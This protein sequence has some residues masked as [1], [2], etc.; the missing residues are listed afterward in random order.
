[1]GKDS[2]ENKEVERNVPQLTKLSRGKEKKDWEMDEG[3]A[4]CNININNSKINKKATK[5]KRVKVNQEEADPSFRT[6]RD[7]VDY[8]EENNEKN[9][10]ES[11]IATINYYQKQVRAISQE[12][13]RLKNE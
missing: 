2:S 4:F 11:L 6:K 7:V 13:Y 8:L 12:N 5:K 9:V 3:I 10:I 1:M